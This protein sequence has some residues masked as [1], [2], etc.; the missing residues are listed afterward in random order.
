[1]VL[2]TVNDMVN[3]IIMAGHNNSQIVKDKDKIML[4]C[5]Y[6]VY[7]YLVILSYKNVINQNHLRSGPT[8]TFI[9]S[10][11]VYLPETW[12][13]VCLNSVQNIPVSATEV[14]ICT[15]FIDPC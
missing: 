15:C 6:T 10:D 11:S 7:K 12:R 5:S 2:C 4:Q 8:V 9:Y 13:K 14:N 1:V 3:V